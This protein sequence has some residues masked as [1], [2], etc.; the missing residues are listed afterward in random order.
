MSVTDPSNL[1]G[2]NF[3]AIFHSSHTPY[4]LVNTNLP[5]YTVA[6]V[7]RAFLNATKTTREALI[8]KP[9]FE[10]FAANPDGSGDGVY[11]KIRAAFDTAVKTQQAVEL[12]AHR[13]DT[14]DPDTGKYREIYWISKIVP[15]LNS[16]GIPTHI[17]HSPIDV[18][19][20][21]GALKRIRA[22]NRELEEQRH[23]LYQVFMQAP[24]GIA[25]VLGEDYVV[26]LANP[27]VCEMY[28]RTHEELMG[29]PIFSVMTET[30]N[31]GFEQLLYDVYHTGVS[32]V[33][34]EMEVPLKRNGE[35]KQVFVNFV[36]EPFRDSTGKVIGIVAIVIDNTEQ[37]ESKRRLADSEAQFRFMAESMPQQVWTA[38]ADGALDYVNEGTQD[39][40]GRDAD[41]IVGAGWQEFIHPDDLQKC[42]ETWVH[43]LETGELYQVQFRLRRHDGQYRW[44]LG[45]ALPFKSNQRVVKWLGTNTDIEEQKRN[46]QVKDEFMSIASHELK[47]PLT[48]LKAYL[49]LLERSQ[50][51]PDEPKRFVQKS[52]HQVKR[53]ENLVN[54][55]LDVSKIV[56]GKLH[57]NMDSLELSQLIAETVQ[58]EQLSAPSHQFIIQSNPAVTIHG[59]QFRLE[60]VM[61]NFLSN[62]VKYSPNADKVIITSQVQG[63]QV[64]VSIED[65]GIGIEK[66]QLD[67]L[68][69]RFYRVN[70]PAMNFEGLGLGLY[71]ASEILT[72]HRGNFWIESDL[73]KGSTFFFRLPI[74]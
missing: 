8:G 23:Q 9:V 67:K 22:A 17:L 29:K 66:D 45:R 42:V 63:G 44:H 37:V 41:D 50:S 40:F 74:E 35:I 68:F 18:T 53:L 11:D 57:Y 30:A 36:Y 43:S 46:E 7:N 2:I 51:V 48:S 61:A 24:V 1:P 28:G 14:I 54:D 39:Y 10:I 12:P 69:D 64:V 13:F 59:D 38:N 27:V 31:K 25:I 49:Q 58:S 62:A 33:G 65:F 56:G 52:V 32:F 34:T 21:Y 71:V 16:D 55:L 5:E 70:N 6:D 73:G 60:Q 19:T 72:R 20:Q 4:I 26:D 3:D 47:T 15:I